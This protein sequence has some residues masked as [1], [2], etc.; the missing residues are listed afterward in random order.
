MV[1]ANPKTVLYDR[2]AKKEV[3]Q[4]VI[5]ADQLADYIR[6]SNAASQNESYSDAEMEALARFFLGINKEQKTDFTAKFREEL[7]PQAQPITA[8]AEPVPQAPSPE[9]AAITEKKQLLCPKC[10]GVMVTRKATKGPNAGKEFY[11]CS[12]YPRCR[13][14]INI[15]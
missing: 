13:C 3:R 5:R 14:I 10:G 2:Y 7:T 4:Q 15:Q 8:P 1:L 11:G 6:K 12:N 9:E